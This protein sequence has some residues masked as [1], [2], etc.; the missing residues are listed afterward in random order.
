MIVSLAYLADH[1]QRIH[2]GPLVAP[3]SFRH[4]TLLARQAAALDDLSGG[5]TILGLGAGWQDREHRMFGHDLGDVPTRM[6]RLEE[7][8]E[9]IT[10]LLN[11]N[12]PVTY[13]GKFFQLRGATLLPRPQRL[14][15]P[16]IMIG[17]NGPKRT[18]P[19]VARYAD[20]WNGNFLSPAAFHERSV[21]L[22]QLLHAAGRDPSEVKRTVMLSLT[23]GRDMAELD[24][25]LSWRRDN[26]QYAGKSL[27]KV[28]EELS[29]D[30]GTII[31]TPDMIIEQI[32]AYAK[33]GA[34]E[35]VLQW[36]DLDDIDGLR[37]F[38]TSVLPQL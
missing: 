16:E 7:G 34:A 36:L 2:F 26:P 29:M 6:A 37:A 38:A 25:K 19:L 10:R 20:I 23:F 17:G 13:E 14:R 1:T 15:G 32:D 30:G 33:A 11:S 21:T 31:G 12:E 5:R 24:R 18:L 3:I 8:L 28:I 27:D 4:P 9:V 22:D 35:L